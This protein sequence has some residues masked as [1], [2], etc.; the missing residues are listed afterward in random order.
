M[1]VVKVLHG[2]IGKKVSAPVKKTLRSFGYS[3]ASKNPSNSLKILVVAASISQKS[4][5]IDYKK[6]VTHLDY[7][8]CLF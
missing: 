7:A 1:Y 4:E 8:F 6:G 5:K 3:K 2:Y